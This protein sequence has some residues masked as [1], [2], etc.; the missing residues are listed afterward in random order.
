MCPDSR[1]APGEMSSRQK[2]RANSV[3]MSKGNASG[4]GLK[5]PLEKAWLTSRAL[6]DG[7]MPTLLFPQRENDPQRDRVMHGT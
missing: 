6:E 5:V 3:I 1:E 4:P 2:L 7:L